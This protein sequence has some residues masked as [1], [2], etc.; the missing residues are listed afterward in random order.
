MDYNNDN[1]SYWKPFEP[2]N[3]TFDLLSIDEHAGYT[4]GPF[5]DRVNFL[6]DN[7]F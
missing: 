6:K 2:T 3:S 5:V 7:G 1:K 4:K